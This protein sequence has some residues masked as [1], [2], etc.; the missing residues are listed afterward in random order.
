MDWDSFSIRSSVVHYVP[1]TKDEA[2]PRPLLTSAEI[3]LDADLTR[4]FAT[5][6]SERLGSKGL[7]VVNDPDRESTVSDALAA[8]LA[9]PAELVPQSRTVAQRLFDVQSG[10]NSSG[11][12]ALLTGTIEG[13]ACVAVVKL[14]RQRGVSFDI[15][16]STGTVDLELMRNLTLTDKTKVYKT[17]L[18]TSGSSGVKLSGFV[19][20]DQRT[21]ARGRQVGD[22][23]LAAFLG[24][25]PKEPA[26]L[27]TYRFVVAANEA[28][29]Q[30]VASAE[31]RGRYQVAMLS[32]LQDNS[33]DIRPQTFAQ[34]H[35]DDV[36][37]APFLARIE[38][39]G[40]DPK[41]PF[42]K[43]T[44]RVKVDQFKVTFD[45]G[46]T[47]VGPAPALQEN[48]EM[49]EKPGPQHPVQ[50]KDTVRS[51]ITGR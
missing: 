7:E 13:R 5:K 49:P 38:A 10:S 30:D 16:S 12:L 46:M 25:K 11:L 43:D 35:L 37:R 3:K 27:T 28:I 34:R 29:N 36:H 23:F 48:V 39:A 9:S 2:D 21:A 18:F 1:T 15:D 32:M 45:S 8:I 19:A 22:F 33:V 6:I 14:E 20:D 40:I 4:Y 47:L 24:C 41:R 50:L 44:S 26:A 31:R 51:V 42:P 17:A